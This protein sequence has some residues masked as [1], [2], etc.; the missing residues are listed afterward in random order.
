MPWK[1]CELWSWSMIIT[2]NVIRTQSFFCRFYY[3][4]SVINIYLIIFFL[5]TFDSEVS[6]ED[7]LWYTFFTM[8]L[9]CLLLL[10]VLEFPCITIFK[11]N[12]ET[13]SLCCKTI[14]ILGRIPY[15][16]VEHKIYPFHIPMYFQKVQKDKVHQFLRNLEILRLLLVIIFLLFSDKLNW[17]IKIWKKW[18]HSL[19]S[20][21]FRVFFFFFPAAE[22]NFSVEY[23]NNLFLSVLNNV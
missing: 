12:H 8:L 22:N 23:S 5:L 9:P 18:G 20:S 21:L 4:I 7:F 16:G 15:F 10:M 1:V 2:T 3:H 19:L 13:R 14:C 17:I 6:F 11:Y